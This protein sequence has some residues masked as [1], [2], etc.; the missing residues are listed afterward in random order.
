MGTTR[1][2]GWHGLTFG[3]DGSRST[4]KLRELV[5][6]VADK[7]ED[8]PTF[9]AVKLNKILFYADFISFAEYGEPITGVKYKKFQ[10][11]P[12]PTILKRVRAEMEER[13]EVVVRKKS[14]YG[15][16]QHRLIP[17]RQPDF[18]L[19]G[20]RDIALVDD[21][22]RML[23]NRSAQEVSEISHDRAW[24]NA[25]EGETIPYEAAFISDEP[26]TERDVA[27]AEE[28]IAEYE[29]FEQSAGRS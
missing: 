1:D 14:H 27:I 20:A 26:L 9:G 19:L 22:I 18:G 17:L 11:G 13:G 24:R 28:M 7:C 5:L 10:Q 8:D 25:S 21:V 4:D 6:Y 12:V 29:R 16:I 3:S 23:W 2:G 15:R